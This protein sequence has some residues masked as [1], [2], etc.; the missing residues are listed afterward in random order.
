ML[1]FNMI[2]VLPPLGKYKYDTW[3]ILPVKYY[4]D[5]FMRLWSCI[6]NVNTSI[7]TTRK[8]FVSVG[9]FNFCRLE[10]VNERNSIFCRL[11]GGPTEDTMSSVSW[12]G[13]DVKTYTYA[14]GATHPTPP[15]CSDLN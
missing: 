1:I 14:F 11:Q 10:W 2:E 9:Y 8:W 12:V 7:F 6:R 3:R 4:I 15:A 5:N 13:A